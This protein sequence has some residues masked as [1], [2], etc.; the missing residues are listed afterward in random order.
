MLASSTQSPGGAT[1]LVTLMTAAPGTAGNR[2]CPPRP[3]CLPPASARGSAAAPEHHPSS[4]AT[5][6]AHRRPIRIV[7]IAR[8]DVGGQRLSSPGAATMLGAGDHVDAEIVRQHDIGLSQR[9]GVQQ[10]SASFANTRSR[11]WSRSATGRCRRRGTASRL[12]G[13]RVAHRRRREREFVLG[14][15]VILVLRAGAR[16]LC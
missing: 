9:I 4:S 7:R 15:E 1:W 2:S 3:A 6:R 5:S 13:Q 12:A 10:R 14:E 8:I 16:R 11:C